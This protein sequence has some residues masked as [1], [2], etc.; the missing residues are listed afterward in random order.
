ML[1]MGLDNQPFPVP[2]AET[3]SAT[4]HGRQSAVRNWLPISRGLLRGMGCKD[5]NVRHVSEELAPD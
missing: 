1:S 4:M 5:V 3:F 2:V